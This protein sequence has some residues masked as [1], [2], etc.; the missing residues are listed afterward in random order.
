L[1]GAAEMP[2]PPSMPVSRIGS[3][4][5]LQ[6]APLVLPA[7][8]A[9]RVIDG[10]IG[11]G[12]SPSPVFVVRLWQRPEPVAPMLCRRRT[13]STYF[14]SRG[15]GGYL[16]SDPVLYAQPII[17][18][19]GF[20]TT[21]PEPATRRRCE[22]LT[23]FATGRS[24]APEATMSAINL[25]TEAM[26]A[27]SSHEPLPFEIRCRADQ[28][29]RGCEDARASL[30]ALPLEA[31]Y[32]VDFNTGLYRTISESPTQ[33]ERVTVRQMV[34]REDGSPGTPTILFGNSRPDGLSWRITLISA[35][36]RVAEVQMQRTMVIYH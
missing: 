32:G 25:L 26:A 13:H 19:D 36:V 7:E 14:M 30:A 27:A 8:E 2:Q 12:I 16:D 9:G 20:A 5:P 35:G 11:R 22:R 3:M 1:L 24:G 6:L 33:S 31:M 4:T 18:A 17:S 34:R 28:G 15:V 29:A 10:T 23:A 21:Y